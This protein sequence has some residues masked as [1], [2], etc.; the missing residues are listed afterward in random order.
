MLASKLRIL[1]IFLGGYVTHQ[2]G[3]YVVEQGKSYFVST[4]LRHFGMGTSIED[5]ERQLQNIPPSS[6]QKQYKKS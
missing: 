1:G 2:V 6:E 4:A 3:D 5:I